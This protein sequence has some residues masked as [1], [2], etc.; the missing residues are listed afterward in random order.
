MLETH[1][2]EWNL[3]TEKSLKDKCEIAG[4]EFQSLLTSLFPW[5]DQ[6]SSGVD[7]DE[8]ASSYFIKPDVFLRIRPGKGESTRRKL[9]SAHIPFI[10]IRENSLSVPAGS[11]VD[12]ELNIDAEAVVQDM[13]SQRVGDY[14]AKVIS[15]KDCSVWDCCAA[16]GGKSIMAYDINPEINLTVS[17]VR[18]QILHNL[19]NRFS[20]AGINNYT[21][22]QGD[23]T[24]G[25]QPVPDAPFDV[26]IAD[27]PC[28]GSGTW[29]RTP[30]QLFY[31]EESKMEEYASLQKNIV[32]S[33]AKQL[34]PGGHLLYITCS[35]FRKENEEVVEYIQKE[36]GLQVMETALLN[37]I[38]EKADVM[39]C[40]LFSKKN[41]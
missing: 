17:D 14:L 22:F 33:G 20:A 31:F 37:G 3:H 26:I 7:Y 12:R 19:D 32:S 21:S 34:K 39:F 13:S 1:K 29:G 16:S 4:I 18:E 28:T 2:P 9:K 40:G 38:S 8:L 5:K 15:E 36:L 35:L 41:N 30:E 6:L 23:L 24:D 25:T 10:E 11:K 27:V